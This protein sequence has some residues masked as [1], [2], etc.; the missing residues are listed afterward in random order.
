MKGEDAGDPAESP[1]RPVRPFLG[2]GTAV[3]AFPAAIRGERTVFFSF[4]ASNWQ[5]WY[6]ALFL[7]L[8]FAW[9]LAVVIVCQLESGEGFGSVFEVKATAEVSKEDKTQCN[10]IRKCRF[11]T[12]KVSEIILDISTNAT[13]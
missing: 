2:L 13:S 9:G 8:W 12:C 11:N 6:S 5:L 3:G 4:K 1:L 7:A 10:E